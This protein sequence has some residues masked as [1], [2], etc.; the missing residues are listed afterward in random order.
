MTKHFNRIV[1]RGSGNSQRRRPRHG[2]FTMLELQVAVILLAFGVVTLS[3]LMA[4]QSRLLSRL[5]GNIQSGRTVVITRSNDPLVKQL[6]AEA[7]ITADPITQSAVPTVTA[8]NTVN[9]VTQE[10][11]LAAES[12]TVTADV[13]EIP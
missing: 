5:R 3:S 2:G 8:H 12:I 6:N 13:A 1:L 10:T 4:T 11:G 7:R 9:I